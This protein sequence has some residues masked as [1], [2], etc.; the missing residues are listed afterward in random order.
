MGVAI[1][2]AAKSNRVAV[3]GSGISGLSAA[4][5]LSKSRNVTLYEAETRVGGHSN[6]VDVQ[7][8]DGNAVPVDTGFIV[9]NERNYPN[10]VALFDHLGVPT[11]DSDMSFAASMEDGRFEYSG[12]GASGLIG[13]R[14]NVIRPRF[15]RMMADI[16]RFY[17]HAP[18]MARDKDCETMTLGEF[19]ADRRFS[20][21][22]IEDHL[23][24]MGAA[25]WSVTLDEMRDYP[26]MAFLRF[27]ESHGLLSLGVRPKWRTVQGGSREYVRRIVDDFSGTLRLASPVAKVERLSGGGVRV[28]DAHGHV[29]DFADVVIATHAK[30]ALAMLADADSEERAL[31]GAFRYSVNEA[32]LHGDARLMPKRKAVWSS[33]NYL[34]AAGSRE[35][36]GLCVSYWMNRLQP[37]GNAPDIFVTLNPVR[38]VDPSKVH[39]RFSYEHPLFD[40]HAIAAQQRLWQ[41]QGKGGV[42]FC[43]AHFGAGFHEDGL[44]AGLATAEALAGVKRPWQ[45]ERES[46][47]IF[48]NT[49]AEAAE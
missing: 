39:A 14:S 30:E 35:G 16:V 43:G 45:V 34:D 1:N 17:R 21:A 19:V 13:Q 28:T 40:R 10:L 8:A 27:F 49:L 2:L 20:K 36:Q 5:L 47:R 46:G 37:L 48:L 38:E 23:L 25:I 9:Y 18:A 3:I 33:W 22:F 24:P 32:V 41:L 42:W 26:L 12:T 6:T 4:W 44:Q 29:D 15:W 31:L 7:L 11:A